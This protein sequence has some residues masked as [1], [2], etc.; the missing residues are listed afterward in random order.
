MMK[1]AG[2]E[3]CFLIKTGKKNVPGQEEDYEE[4]RRAQACVGPHRDDILFYIN[5]NSD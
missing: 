4:I 2:I 5:T 3:K 1:N